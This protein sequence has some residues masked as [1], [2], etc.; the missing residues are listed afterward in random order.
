M[1]QDIHDYFH[2]FFHD[3]EVGV[4]IVACAL[5]DMVGAFTD[6]CSVSTIVLDLN[7]NGIEY[8]KND[9]VSSIFYDIDADKFAEKTEWIKPTDGFLVRDLN[10][11][12]KID[13]QAEMFGDN[14]GTNAY[15]KLA[16]LDTNHDNKITAADTAWNTI[17][18]WQDLNSD[19]KTD[20]G[21]LKTL[22]QLGIT[23]LSLQTSTTSYLA[24]HNVAVN[25]NEKILLAAVA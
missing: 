16:L 10:G 5:A 1:G 14:G 13:S 4:G 6:A 17:K 12:G 8:I 21:E 20:A 22:D 15:A 24:G 23:S 3:V 11:N 7:N 2:D 18:V 25:D 19:G 9:S